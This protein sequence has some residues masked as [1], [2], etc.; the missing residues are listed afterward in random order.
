MNYPYVQGGVEVRLDSST[1][2]KAAGFSVGW[3]SEV[4]FFGAERYLLY[5]LVVAIDWLLQK[6]A[7]RVVERFLSSTCVARTRRV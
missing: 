4:S 6:V 5:R 2:R 3:Q 1:G 7:N